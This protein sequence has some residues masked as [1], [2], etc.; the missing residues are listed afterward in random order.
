MRSKPSLSRSSIVSHFAKALRHRSETRGTG[1]IRLN[2]SIMAASTVRLSAW[3]L[4]VIGI[5]DERCQPGSPVGLCAVRAASS[6][7]AEELF[8]GGGRRLSRRKK[9]SAKKTKT[10]WRSIRSDR[11]SQQIRPRR[12][13]TIAKPA[14]DTSAFASATLP[15]GRHGIRSGIACSPIEKPLNWPLR[16][17]ECYCFKTS[18]H[19]RKP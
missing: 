5:S 11:A 14:A 8:C 17:I 13:R 6:A 2:R 18:P 12:T 3:R 16:L 4:A 9:R 15:E 7:L 1:V 19:P 10:W